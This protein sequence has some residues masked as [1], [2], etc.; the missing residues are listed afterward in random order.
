MHVDFNDVCCPT[1]P[2]QCVIGP[3]GRGK[4]NLSLLQ[5]V[6]LHQHLQRLLSSAADDVVLPVPVQRS[7]QYHVHEHVQ[8]S[9]PCSSGKETCEVTGSGKY[10]C[11]CKTL[12]CLNQAKV[13][14]QTDKSKTV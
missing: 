13:I 1:D 8:A 10:R 5:L 6:F 4:S 12:A 11:T 9:N 3:G 2:E 14:I 7:L